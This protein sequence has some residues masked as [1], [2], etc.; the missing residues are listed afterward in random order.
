MLL[1]EK[2]GS[3]LRFLARAAETEVPLPAGQRVLSPS[4]AAVRHPKPPR[5]Y[6]SRLLKK[7]SSWQQQVWRSSGC[8]VCRAVRVFYYSYYAP[9]A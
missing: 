8:I 6:G 2:S 3:V 4:L 7:R 5:S 1:Y 9:Q